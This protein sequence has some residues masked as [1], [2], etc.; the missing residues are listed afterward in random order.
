MGVHGHLSRS[1]GAGLA[2]FGAISLGSSGCASTHLVEISSRPAETVGASIFLN[3]EKRGVTPGKVRIDFGP[4]SDQRVL[5]Q[6]VKPNYKPGF[7]YWTSVEV[8]KKQVF[9]LEDE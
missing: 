8:P 9:D 3:G 1:L 6:I 5:I 4:N 2:L 7:Q